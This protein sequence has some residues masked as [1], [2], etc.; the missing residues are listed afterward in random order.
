MKNELV[1]SFPIPLWLIPALITLLRPQM[2]PS[3]QT[4]VSNK[5]SRLTA[6][7]MQDLGYVINRDAA[8]IDTFNVATGRVAADEGERIVLTGCTDKARKRGV[9]FPV[10]V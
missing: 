10:P 8:E 3:L 4:G 7:S 1:S 9:K 6:Y 2:S 5:L